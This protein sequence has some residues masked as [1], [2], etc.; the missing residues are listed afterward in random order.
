TA[1]TGGGGGPNFL[2][3]GLRFAK[4]APKDGAGLRSVRGE[5][6]AFLRFR[7]GEFSTGTMGNFQPVL[8]VGCVMPN[9]SQSSTPTHPGIHPRLH[10]TEKR[11][12]RAGR[13]RTVT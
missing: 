11:P 13:P 10:R 3:L 5:G 9:L 8:T 1:R 4:N 6:S 7:G 12:R 2:G